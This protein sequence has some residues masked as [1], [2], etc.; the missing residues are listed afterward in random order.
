M[1]KL[2][3]ILC[4]GIALCMLSSCIVVGADDVPEIVIDKRTET[5]KK[6]DKTPATITQPVTSKYSI[7]C[8]NSTPF[9]ITDWCVKNGSQ[10]TFSNSDFNRSIRA[11][12]ED[13]IQNLPEGYYKIFFSF[14]DQY[15]L[16][17]WDYQSSESI[18]LNQN[19]TYCLYTRQSEQT[20]YSECRSATAEGA[21]PEFYLEGSDGS[22]IE[23]LCK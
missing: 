8:K 2:L 14:E 4:A 7:T 13:M 16:N 11:Y 19:V 12:G 3:S 23:L 1:K 22:R 20:V 6:E 18:Y 9:T 17:P 21:K 15:Q 10:V 5:P